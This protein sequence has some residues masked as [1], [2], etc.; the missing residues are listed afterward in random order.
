MEN[1]NPLVSVV[2][3][4]YKRT[5]EYVSKAVQSVLNQTYQNIEIVVIDDSTEAFEGRKN[6]ENYFKSL[7][8][9][10]VLYLQNEK[11]LGGSLSRNRGIENAKGEYITFLDDDDEYKPEKIEKQLRFMIENDCDMTFSNTGMCKN[12]H[13]VEVRD[14]KD[15]PAYDNES[16]L[17]YHLLYHLTGTSTYMFKAEK[18][19][20]I[21]GFDNALCGQE[22]ILTL[23]AIEGGLRIRYMDVNVVLHTISAEGSISFSKNKIQG[24]KNL[25]QI[26][27]RY[28]PKLSK[29]EI[30]YVK[31]RYHAIMAIA[32]RRNSIYH[33]M[34]GEGITA[35]AT[36]PFDFVGECAALLKNTIEQRTKK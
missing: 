22:F 35:V 2:I 11:N 12:G 23:K 3:P 32:Y 8:A 29:K 4:T 10:N 19:R 6:T 31:F 25:Y 14:F 30:R 5:V 24:E 17:R 27:T 34:I 28:F 13:P 7:N 1:N 16:L 18:L 20:Q 15:I 36:S 33:K 26:K 21:G 9:P